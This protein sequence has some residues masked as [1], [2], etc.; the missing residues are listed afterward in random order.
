VSIGYLKDDR[1]TPNNA[2][3][4]TIPPDESKLIEVKVNGAPVASVASTASADETDVAKKKPEVVSTVMNGVTFDMKAGE[5]LAIVGEVGSGKSAII[6]ALLGEARVLSGQAVLQGSVAYLP[7][8]PWIQAGTVRE[9][10]LF[11]RP[12]NHDR[13]TR[14]VHACGLL[15]DLAVLPMG[16]RTVCAE[17]GLNLS[18]GQRQRVSLARAVYADAQVYLLDGPL[19]AV[20][21]HTSAH[22]MQH[23][24]KGLLAGKTVILV[25]HQ[26]H[27]LDQFN[28]IV[29]HLLPRTR[30][31][32]LSS[33]PSS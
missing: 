26:L 10:V 12:Y 22:I 25:T 24:F 16:D 8:N 3:H 4:T 32:F 2:V 7:Q 11:G 31:S 23:C 19:S 1:Q 29:R 21:W 6:D 27:L 18:G 33:P 20:D 17:R 30:C 9:N 28:Y 13:Y 15:P 14:V 5:S